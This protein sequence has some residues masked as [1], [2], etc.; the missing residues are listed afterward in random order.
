MLVIMLVLLVICGIYFGDMNDVVLMLWKLVCDSW[1]MSVIFM[2]VGMKV[3]LFCSLLCGL[4]L[5]ILMVVG[6][7]M[8]VFWFFFVVE[9]SSC[10]CS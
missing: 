8:V 6:N 5:M 9:F 10:V 4:I 1:L 3:F 7:V 2:L